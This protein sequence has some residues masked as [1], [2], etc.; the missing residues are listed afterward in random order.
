MIL[1]TPAVTL[2]HLKTMTAFPAGKDVPLM[3]DQIAI[4]TGGRIHVRLVSLQ[5]QNRKSEGGIDLPDIIENTQDCEC[6]VL[7][8]SQQPGYE[9]P[10]WVAERI[11]M[12]GNSEW[13]AEAHP[14]LLAEE[15]QGLQELCAQPREPKVKV[16]DRCLFDV[17]LATQVPGIADEFFIAEEDIYAI[18]TPGPAIQLISTQTDFA[19]YKTK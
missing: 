3:T 2:G 15:V 5:T 18:V 16:G 9:L 13:W 17:T 6:E 4:P 10:Q 7:A 11:V 14:R 1:R 19:G 8:V 12:R